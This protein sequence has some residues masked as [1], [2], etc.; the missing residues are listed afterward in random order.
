MSLICARLIFWQ[1]EKKIIQGSCKQY[2][3]VKLIPKSKSK[4]TNM[5]KHI[6]AENLIKLT[7]PD[8]F[9]TVLTSSMGFDCNG[10]FFQV[11]K[12]TQ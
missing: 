9:V 7:K 3:I 11:L 10:H 8:K 12:P 1:S 6:S 5:K 4:E 2:C